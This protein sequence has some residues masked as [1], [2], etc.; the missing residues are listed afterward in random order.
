KDHTLRVWDAESGRELV[1]LR[2][3]Q[4]VSG[5]QALYRNVYEDG[6]KSVGFSPNGRLI[7]SGSYDRTV[8]LWDWASASELACLTGHENGV[9]AVAFSPDGRHIV[10]ASQDE[11]IRLWEAVP[12][13]PLTPLYRHPSPLTHL[14]F[15]P[16]GQMLVSGSL[17]G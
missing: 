7:V 14:C 17:D 3:H 8:R 13:I 12:D 10:S 16:N 2:G 9:T 4:A 11:T 15:S 5:E 6:V 1:C